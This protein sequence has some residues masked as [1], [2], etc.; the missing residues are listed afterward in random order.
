MRWSLV[1]ASLVMVFGLT[2]SVGA[3]TRCYPDDDGLVCDEPL[4]PD[5]R[6]RQSPWRSRP[7]D[8]HGPRFDWTLDGAR[9]YSSDGRV[10]WPHGD[11]FHCAPPRLH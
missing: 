8:G 9:V 2:A 4:N 10:C 11:H 5:S 7:A 6:S 3:E 1:A